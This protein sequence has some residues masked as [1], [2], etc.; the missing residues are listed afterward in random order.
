MF[1]VAQ[2]A[3]GKIYAGLENQVQNTAVGLHEFSG[4]KVQVILFHDEILARRLREKNIKVHVIP[5]GFFGYFKSVNMINKT[6]ISEKIDIVHSHGYKANIVAYHASKKIPGIYRIRSE[7]GLPEPFSGFKLLKYR[8]YDYYDRKIAAGHTH[9]V[10]AVSK[11]VR[12]YLLE[13]LPETKVLYLHNSIGPGEETDEETVRKIR[14]ELNISPGMRIIGIIGRL[15]PVKNH[16]LFIDT[17][18][19]LSELEKNV[20]GLIVGSGPLENDLKEYAKKENIADRVIFAGFRNDIPS[21]L[22]MLDVLMFTSLH[23]GLPMALLEAM[24]M[25]TPVISVKT[26]GIAEVLSECC[27][28]GLVDSYDPDKLARKCLELLNDPT[29]KNK[30][31]EAA[32][33]MVKEL[34]SLES[35]THKLSAIYSEMMRW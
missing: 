34:F 6:L 33:T 22:G 2:I 27:P 13:F 15:V 7:H 11:D 12:D 23:E 10:I 5:V 1:N 20:I 35:Y 25:G 28:E 21:V 4:N 32:L 14:T 17:I 29:L 24:N 8:M 9:R 19:R 30:I 31:T 18:K 16:R 3:S 26:G